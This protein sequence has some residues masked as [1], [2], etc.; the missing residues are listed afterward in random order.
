MCSQLLEIMHVVLVE[1]RAL[2]GNISA[3][4]CTSA[5]NADE[6]IVFEEWDNA[7]SNL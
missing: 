4:S 7:S 6:I 2:K 3:S 1:S 5:D